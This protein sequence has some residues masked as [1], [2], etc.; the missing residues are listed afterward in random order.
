LGRESYE[1]E[2]LKN[3]GIE[4]QVKPKSRRILSERLGTVVTR[5]EATLGLQQVSQL[6]PIGGIDYI[7]PRPREVERVTVFSADVATGSMQSDARALIRYLNSPEAALTAKTGLE[8]LPT[9][10]LGTATLLRESAPLARI[11]R[12]RPSPS[13]A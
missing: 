11:A 1:T 6:L 10:Q 8:P 2:L 7:G 3:L 4:A 9:M 5:G 12:T 13:P